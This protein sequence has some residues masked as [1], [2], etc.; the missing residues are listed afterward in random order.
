PAGVREQ[1]SDVIERIGVERSHQK[2]QQ[3]DVVI[4]LFDVSEGKATE[5][6]EIEQK[7]KEQNI[8]YLL[9]GNKSDLIEHTALKEKF[10]S[11]HTL[12]IS[13]KAKKNINELRK[14][15]VGLV[16]EGQVNLENTIVTNARHYEALQQVDKSL[17]DIR[18]GLN[19]NLP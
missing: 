12:F 16:T 10:N 6:K 17:E 7:L 8:N 18:V 9:V 4:Y 11:N 14:H 15:L 5:L 1:T 19:S 13:A 2:M 3:S